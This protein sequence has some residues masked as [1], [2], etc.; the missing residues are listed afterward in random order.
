MLTLTEN[1][2]TIVKTIAAQTP[3]AES[4]GGLRISSKDAESTDFTV[5][6]TPAPEPQ[7][8]V[9]ESSGARVFLEENAAVVLSDKVL[10]AQVDDEGAVRF[11]IGLPQA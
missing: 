8:L 5:A 4:D 7:D 1:A 11:A 9:V 3:G 2:S 6:V 10:D